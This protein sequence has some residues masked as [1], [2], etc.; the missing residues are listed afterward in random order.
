MEFSVKSHRTAGCGV[1]EEVRRSAPGVSGTGG[2]RQEVE[3]IARSEAISA[4][5]LTSS[6]RPGA[7]NNRQT[8]VVV[9]FETF[10]LGLMA[11]G[12]PLTVYACS[13]F[14]RG[15]Q[16]ENHTSASR[17]SGYSNHATESHSQLNIEGNVTHNAT[18]CS[19]VRPRP[20]GKL[21]R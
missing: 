9:G 3:K 4:G 5:R 11:S 6:P 18:G 20:A 10:K 19:A 1:R 16:G 17:Y 12:P 8:G 13:R 15:R 21:S 2:Y 14:S 7:N